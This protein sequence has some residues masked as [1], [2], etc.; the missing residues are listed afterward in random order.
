MIFLLLLLLSSKGGT[1]SGRSWMYI[2]LSAPSTSKQQKD[3]WEG[4]VGNRTE[5]DSLPTWVLWTWL[6]LIFEISPQK[7]NANGTLLLSWIVLAALLKRGIQAHKAVTLIL[8]SK[9]VR[10]IKIILSNRK[11]PLSTQKRLERWEKNSLL[12]LLVKSRCRN[13]DQA[14]NVNAVQF[15]LPRLG[16]ALSGNGSWVD[17]FQ[18]CFHLSLNSILHKYCN[19]S[20][21][22]VRLEH[23]NVYNAVPMLPHPGGYF[24]K[25]CVTECQRWCLRCESSIRTGE[26]VQAG[27]THGLSS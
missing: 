12:S 22:I 25:L 26:T 5:N 20:S 24:P 13:L 17:R 6:S 15:P 2:R 4:I 10:T 3:A 14:K 16:F 9:R 23:V 27:R 19:I 8:L 11:K 1:S 21:Y 7:L 18:D